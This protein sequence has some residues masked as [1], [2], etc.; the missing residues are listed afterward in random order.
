MRASDILKRFLDVMGSFADLLSVPQ[1]SNALNVAT[2]VSKGVDQLLGIDDKNMV[3]GYQRT[4]ESAGGG[5]DNELR[6]GY[7]AVINAPSGTYKPQHLWIKDSKLLFGPELAKSREL[8]GVDFMLLR[9]ETRRYRDD[10]DAFSSIS[11]PFTKA[12]NTL[13]QLDAAGKPNVADAAAFIRAAA[14][15]A[16]TSP[17]LTAKDRVQVARVIRNRYN[18]YKAAMLGERSLKAPKPPVLADMARTAHQIND[19]PTTVGQLFP[20]D[21]L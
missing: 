20:S 16:M 3:L 4:L 18:E 21:E 13:M 7:V 10:W 2:A 11:E 15:A 5:G 1:L 9:I 19:S 6:P 8:T 12:M 17:D 14:V